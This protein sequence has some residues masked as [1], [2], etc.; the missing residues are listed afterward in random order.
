MDYK[1][2]ASTGG[3]NGNAGIGNYQS[4]ATYGFGNGNDYVQ[5]PGSYPDNVGNPNLTWELNKPFNI[6]IDAG[7]LKKQNQFYC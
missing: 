1:I 6:G 7:I 4:I 3:V 2:R 5:Q